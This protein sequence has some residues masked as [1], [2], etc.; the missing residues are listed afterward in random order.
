MYVTALTVR[1]M[2]D[3]PHFQASGLGRVV[4]VRG[5]SP[6]ST[7]LGD[8]LAFAMAAFDA[9]ALAALLTRWGLKGEEGTPDVD[10]EIFPS[11]AGWVDAES[12]ELVVDPRPHASIRVDLRLS[13][14]PP[15]FGRLRAEAAREPKLVTALSQGAEVELT[16][17]GLFNKSRTALAINLDRFQV[18]DQRFPTTEKERPLWMTQVLQ[19]LPGRLAVHDPAQ[20]AAEM[21]LFAMTSRAK[22]GQF[23][24]WQD[25]L[26]AKTARATT[27]GRIRPV[28][29]TDGQVGLMADDRALRSWGQ[30]AQDRASLSATVHLSGADIVWAESADKWLDRWVEGDGSPLEQV[31]RVCNRG[32]LVPENQPL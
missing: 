10:G 5:P 22:H 4:T 9:E 17:T 21:A 29:T 8:A 2:R 20:N 25:S 32:E 16:I 7:A 31:W 30:A 27:P 28:L 13:L 11:H 3:L 14:D 23:T 15:L 26:M 24:A 1:G 19:E 6:Q 12:A 18:G